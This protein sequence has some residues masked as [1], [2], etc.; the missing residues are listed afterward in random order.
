MPTVNERLQDRQIRHATYIERVKAGTVN[1]LIAQLSRTE[2]DLIEQI[3]RRV[4]A[5][6][7]RGYD[8]GPVTTARLNAA[9]EQIRE[10][11]AKAYSSFGES[12]RED[13]QDIGKDEARFQE[14]LLRDVLPDV[15]VVE[16]GVSR[17][18]L[19][20]LFSIVNA[21][22][23]QGRLL[24]E[25][26]SSLEAD[27]AARVRDQIR[28]GL[29]EGE[30]IDSIVRR[31]R[32]TRSLGY[33]DGVLEIS[34]R[35]AAA[36]VRTAVNHTVSVAR[37][38]VYEDNAD[39]IKGVEWSSTLDTRTCPECMGLDGKVFPVKSG[40]RPPAHFACRCSTVPVTKSW[41]E[42]GFDIDE[43][44]GTRAS[45]NGQVP[46]T[47]DYGQWLR[48]QSRETVEDALG[49][50]RADLFIKGKLDITKFTDIRGRELTLKQLRS[51]EADV[52]RK[53]GVD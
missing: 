45:M 51:R 49:P 29:V 12:L 35:N 44:R 26:I 17:P 11:K 40:R 30:D 36:V 1:K 21:R 39:I 23:F 6:A 32:G 22:P 19:R 46:D 53:A 48:K 20:S 14:G 7:E 41:K 34:R 10:I 8:T 28:I 38:A 9:L 50:T 4:G 27:A 5:I 25:W 33:R 31:I 15:V 16:L 42:L 18:D 43:V 47:L 52:F 24:K 37:E 2:D 13:L 3:R